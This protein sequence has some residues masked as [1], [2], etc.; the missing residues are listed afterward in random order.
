MEIYGTEHPRKPTKLSHASKDLKEDIR[1]EAES[2]KFVGIFPS[3]HVVQE[4]HELD[5]KNH[6]NEDV[7]ILLKDICKLHNQCYELQ[8]ER[9]TEAVVF[10]IG[11]LDRS[12][13]RNTIRCSPVGWFTKGYSLDALT[14]RKIAENVHT[15]CTESGIHVPCQSFDGQWHTLVVRD[16]EGEP[17]TIFQLQK[18]IWRRVEQRSKKD[19]IDEIK[20]L[21]KDVSWT[22]IPS[23]GSRSKYISLTNGGR[24]LPMFKR[25]ARS[26]P[27]ELNEEDEN[28]SVTALIDLVPDI[29]QETTDIGREVLLATSVT[30]ELELEA[31][32]QNT[33]A[34][35]W[36]TELQLD[37]TQQITDNE[38]HI[39]ESETEK[40]DENNNDEF[41][42]DCSDMERILKMLKTT[43]DCNK[44]MQWNTVTPNGFLDYFQSYQKL[45][46]LLDI[47]IRVIVRYLKKAKGMTNVKESSSKQT[48]LD[49]IANFLCLVKSDSTHKTVSSKKGS[50]FHVSSL[51]DLATKVVSKYSK[52]E[53][54]V[55]VAE[56]TFP[57]MYKTW[58][59]PIDDVTVNG[60]SQ[61]WFYKPE[62]SKRRKQ[63]EVKCIDSTH[64]L[65]RAR[66]K[67]CAGGIQ[68]ISNEPWM[69]VARQRKTLLTAIMVEDVSDPMSVAMA[70]THF[71]ESVEIE[72]RKNGDS[73]EADL[74]NDIRTWWEAEDSPGISSVERIQKRKNLRRRLFDLV[75][76]TR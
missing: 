49:K 29:V 9:A 17:L 1:K 41:T 28:H 59:K 45:C 7:S 53:L 37:D 68:G 15:Q 40:I 30:D 34:N 48:K 6:S 11:D 74:V 33:D 64:L 67:T 26:K 10:L 13:K 19:L 46:T 3:C 57:E 38:K 35:K 54:N 63:T 65:T 5:K 76:F 2:A 58:M 72:M 43:K 20:Q 71:S 56:M 24:I 23:T 44:K 62:Y 66:R 75:D 70:K 39:N 16:V 47:E 12:W 50:K 14:M 36:C 22:V 18:D 51:H 69:K 42:L 21:N 55:I 52:H 4:E 8:R 27:K 73:R 61:Q 25:E 31:F 32:S 60:E